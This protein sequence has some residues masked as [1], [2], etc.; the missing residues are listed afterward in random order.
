MCGVWLK[1][2]WGKWSQK[3]FSL[4]FGC[5]FVYV[6]WHVLGDTMVDCCHLVINWTGIYSNCSMIYLDLPLLVECT[7]SKT[8]IVSIN[9]ERTRLLDCITL[10]EIMLSTCISIFLIYDIKILKSCMFKPPRLNP[11]MLGGISFRY[12]IVHVHRRC[13]AEFTSACWFLLTVF[14]GCWILAWLNPHSGRQCPMYW[15]RGHHCHPERIL[16]LLLIIF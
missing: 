13:S 1:R 11:L 4:E 7:I 9:F 8:S 5:I 12:I 3:L 15:L 6:C 14:T 16:I 2:F 10:S